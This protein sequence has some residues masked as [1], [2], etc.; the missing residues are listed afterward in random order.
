MIQIEE[1]FYGRK[2]PHYCVSETPLQL[3]RDE[4]CSWLSVKDEVAGGISH[5]ACQKHRAWTKAPRASNTSSFLPV[6]LANRK[7]DYF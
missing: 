6:E 7:V 4:G 5:M 2:T 1:S 3:D